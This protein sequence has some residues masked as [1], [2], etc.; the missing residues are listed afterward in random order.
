M[1]HLYF[2]SRSDEESQR[3]ILEHIQDVQ[4]RCVTFVENLMKREMYAR[5]KRGTILLED[6]LS[7]SIHLRD[8]HVGGVDH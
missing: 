4:R 7:R 3:M 8:E 1:V 6:Y 5:K 2:P